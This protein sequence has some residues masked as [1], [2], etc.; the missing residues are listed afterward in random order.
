MYT[1][2]TVTGWGS[3]LAEAGF[4]LAEI[5][6]RREEVDLQAGGPARDRLFAANPLGQLPTVLMPDGTVLSKHSPS[7]AASL[8]IRQAKL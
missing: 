1:L 5:P 7:T 2:F 8:V 4:A 3:V 6:Y